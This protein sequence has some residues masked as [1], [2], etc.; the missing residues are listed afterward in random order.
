MRTLA[1]L[2]ASEA[3]RRLLMLG[4]TATAGADTSRSLLTLHARQ[5]RISV[6]LL[7]QW[8]IAYVRSGLAALLPTTWPQLPESAWMLAEQRH[9]SLGALA[10]A[11]I[12]TPHEIDALAAR[13]GWSGAQAH[14][15]L[16]RYR[17]GG[18]LGLV[19]A[20]RMN[21]ASALPDLGSL[22]EQR[23][24]EL[25]R[26]HALLGP[27]AEQEHVPNA[28]MAERAGVVGVSVRTLRSYHTRFRR[29]GLSGLAP[30]SRGDTGRP[31][32]LS[33]QMAHL[34]ESLRLTHRD[35]PTRFIHELAV[36][37]A[38]ARGDAAP[39]RFQVRS[40]CAQIPV[41]VRLLADG[42]EVEFRNRYRLTY[43]IAH[44]A[45]RMVWQIDHKAPVPVLVRD[46]RA[47]S[48]RSARSEVRPYLTLVIDS[49]SRLV[50]AGL[51]S[52]DPPD[53]LTPSHMILALR[54]IP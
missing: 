10:D 22:S 21:A 20:K 15:W 41:P 13:N 7:R 25:F 53:R 3:Q 50:M 46:L 28:V 6:S 36:D 39:S 33:A 43:P 16:R 54:H 47:P 24:D 9:V 32:V 48:H 44:D 42:R 30:R 49:A 18:M 5:V 12:I 26:R 29:D 38:V 11:E 1:Q 31:H 27:L 35:A 14:R 2:Q 23:R 19:P 45:R 40:I 34:I 52:Y 37:A 8:H 17:S 51:F 4:P